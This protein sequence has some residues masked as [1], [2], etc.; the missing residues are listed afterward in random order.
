MAQHWKKSFNTPD[1]HAEGYTVKA[2]L[3][4]EPEIH[5]LLR[6]FPP[7][8]ENMEPQVDWFSDY[9]TET[10]VA[11]GVITQG[12]YTSGNKLAPHLMEHKEYV[13][14]YRILKFVVGLGVKVTKIRKVLT[15]LDE[16]IY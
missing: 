7:C 5:D 11:S 9:Q 3:V 10:G 8:P 1:D 6:P 15:T 12:K 14:D 2:D 13:I 4:M 16:A